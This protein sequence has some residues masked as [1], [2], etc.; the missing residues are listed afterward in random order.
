MREYDVIKEPVVSE[1]STALREKNKVVFKVDVKATK[2]QIKRA[3][4]KIYPDVVVKS[5]N[6][7][8]VQ[9]KKKRVRYVQGRVSAWKKAVL[10][11][12]KGVNQFDFT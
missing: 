11:L 7:S 9:G 6:T 1:K 3:V 8:L 12:E 4:E 10:T 2:D 5:V